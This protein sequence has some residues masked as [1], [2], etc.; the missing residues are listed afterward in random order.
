MFNAPYRQHHCG[1]KEWTYCTAYGSSW[2]SPY[3]QI[4]NETGWINLDGTDDLNCGTMSPNKCIQIKV[5]IIPLVVQIED[6]YSP[7]GALAL[8]VGADAGNLVSTSWGNTYGK[9]FVGSND[10]IVNQKSFEP[11]KGAIMLRTRKAD[12]NVYQDQPYASFSLNFAAYLHICRRELDKDYLPD[13]IVASY[14]R[15][16][17]GRIRLDAGTYE[18]ICYKKLIEPTTRNMF[19]YITSPPEVIYGNRATTDLLD[20]STTRMYIALIIP[21]TEDDPHILTPSWD[22]SF[23][24]LEFWITVGEFGIVWW[25]F[26]Y[27]VINFL[28]K[29]E[30]RLDRLETLMAHYAATG[31]EDS[32]VGAV[33]LCYNQTKSNID[34][35][36]NMYY[37]VLAVKLV[38]LFP[39][40]IL[41]IW[42]IVAVNKV[43]PPAVGYGL[44]FIG[45]MIAL[46][47]YGFCLWRKMGW[48]MTHLA[49]T[50]FNMA[51]ILAIVFIVT[52]VFANPAMIKGGEALNFLSLSVTFGTLNLIPLIFRA[53]SSDKSLARSV[54]QLL[55]T[56][57]AAATK[58][59]ALKPNQVCYSSNS[60]SGGSA[61]SSND[62]E[63]QSS[64]CYL[65]MLVIP[66]SLP[67]YHISSP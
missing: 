23:N 57:G 64:L 44:I 14:K 40:I 25:I 37:A 56:V 5:T 67:N 46:G 60:S 58:A 15:S 24:R 17:T 59:N 42:G 39:F 41:W 38:V 11:L 61:S 33:F 65:L 36:R 54:N 45:T 1:E 13:W 47:G 22:V 31:T 12:A 4:C 32:I 7:N 3:R 62:A 29:I 19:G 51:A 66:L 63:I 27:L 49:F 18:W 8:T 30:L 53:F 9:P 21:Y 20:T 50:C 6:S 55:A 34:Y 35:R 2:V 52:V 26:T 16:T 48:C 28:K 43:N 10:L